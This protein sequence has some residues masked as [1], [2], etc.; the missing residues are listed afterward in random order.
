MNRE[1]ISKRVSL[2]LEGKY[3]EKSR[4]WK[5]NDA[6]YSAKHHWILKHY[7]KASKCEKCGSKNC[8]RYEWANI[9]GEYKRDISDYMQLCPSCHRKM[10]LNKKYCPKGHEYNEKNTY[11]NKFGWKCCRICRAESQRRYYK[12]CKE[13]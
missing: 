2:Q 7:G 4:R 6:S 5:E 3:G 13:I 1:D 12:K 10:D 9:S 11:I 8:K